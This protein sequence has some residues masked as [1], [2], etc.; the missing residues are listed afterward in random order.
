MWLKWDS[1]RRPLYRWF[2]L[3][4]FT[5]E[6]VYTQL[7]THIFLVNLLSNHRN[8]NGEQTMLYVYII[9]IVDLI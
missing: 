3:D 5:F 6:M 7:K 1:N 8:Q 2:D 9:Y 4:L